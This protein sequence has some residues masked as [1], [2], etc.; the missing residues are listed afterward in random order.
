MSVILLWFLLV[1]G[2]EILP[3]AGTQDATTTADTGTSL[4][5]L[6]DGTSWPPPPPPPPPPP[7][8]KQQQ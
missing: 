2:V 7:G 6:D 1:S 5:T 3:L 8:P 4:R